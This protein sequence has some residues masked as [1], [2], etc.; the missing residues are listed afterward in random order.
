MHIEC[1]EAPKSF[2]F[3]AS[4]SI[5]DYTG[6]C[7]C[8]QGRVHTYGPPIKLELQNEPDGQSAFELQTPIP[9]SRSAQTY[10]P[11]PGNVAPPSQNA[12]SVLQRSNGTRVKHAPFRQRLP[13]PQSPSLLQVVAAGQ[14]GWQAPSCPHVPLFD[15]SVV[16]DAPVF[17]CK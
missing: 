9:K 12:H 7:G 14:I 2:V 10:S 15:P 13:A 6:A 8:E 11:D 4:R 16:Q 5:N 17:G 3:G 1:N